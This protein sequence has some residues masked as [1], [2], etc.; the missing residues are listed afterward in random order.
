MLIARLRARRA[1]RRPVEMPH[2]RVPAASAGSSA[3]SSCAAASSISAKPRAGS[4]KCA[5]IIASSPKRALR[6]PPSR[7][8]CRRRFASYAPGSATL[9]KSRSRPR[10]P[11]RA[12][13]RSAQK[14]QAFA[15]SRGHADRVAAH[16]ED[17]PIALRE[18]L[19][20][21]REPC[22]VGRIDRRLVTAIV[23]AQLRAL[24]EERQIAGRLQLCQQRLELEIAVEPVEFGVGR[25][26]VAA[27]LPVDR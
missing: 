21:V 3:P 14:T 24:L 19:Q 26:G 12:P 4:S 9:S 6:T 18:R 22:E 23:T 1:L 17:D 10:G 2:R 15:R 7:I 8:A 16:C 11:P 5:A 20:L 25:L 13:K 27:L